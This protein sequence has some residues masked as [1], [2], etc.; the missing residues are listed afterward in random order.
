MKTLY[1]ITVEVTEVDGDGI[2]RHDKQDIS[3]ENDKEV[4]RNFLGTQFNR[5]VEVEKDGEREW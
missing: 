1:N 2:V 4:V 3:V 5:F